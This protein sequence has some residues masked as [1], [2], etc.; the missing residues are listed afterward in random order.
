M[1]DK[2]ETLPWHCHAFGVV[3]LRRNRPFQFLQ[4][5]RFLQFLH[6]RFD[7]SFTPFVIIRAFFPAEKPLHHRGGKRRQH[8]IHHQAININ[9]TSNINT[10]SDFRKSRHFYCLLLFLAAAILS[11]VFDTLQLETLNRK[12]VEPRW[13]KINIVCSFM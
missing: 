5:A 7:G 1:G 12:Q 8:H 6:Q 10:A 4:S 9:S 3:V 13:R 11:N 2:R